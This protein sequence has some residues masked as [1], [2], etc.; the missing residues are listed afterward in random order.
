MSALKDNVKDCKPPLKYLHPNFMLGTAYGMLAG[1]LKYAAWNFLKGH[2]RQDLL[3]GAIRHLL[4]DRSGEL[5]DAD[6]TA[7]LKA[8]F[9]DKAPEVQH[10]WLAACN[11][12]MILWQQAYGTG[13]N[14]LPT[15]SEISK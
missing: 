5:I 7:R 13:R 6:T 15:A 14:S 8:V 9:G 3:D 10:L 11:I 2:D 12:N 1:E 4:A